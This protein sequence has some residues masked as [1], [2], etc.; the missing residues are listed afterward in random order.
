MQ[1]NIGKGNQEQNSVVFN[2]MIILEKLN[3]NIVSMAQTISE[4]AEQVGRNENVF[5][6]LE[7]L[8]FESNLLA[9]SAS[10]EEMRAREIGGKKSISLAKKISDIA[11]KAADAAQTVECVVGAYRQ[12]RYDLSQSLHKKPSGVWPGAGNLL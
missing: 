7:E 11:G 9:L 10:V 12:V 5:Q 8:A 4:V 6:R 3:N 1:R 2:V